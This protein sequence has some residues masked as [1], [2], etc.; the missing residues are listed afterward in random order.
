ETGKIDAG[1]YESMRGELRARAVTLL[2]AE[3]AERE[4]GEQADRSAASGASAAPGLEA[5]E[6]KR[7]SGTGPGSSGQPA[8]GPHRFCPACGSALTEGWRFCAGCGAE[9]PQAA[10]ESP[11]SQPTR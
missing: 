11:A 6:G 1:E 4:A 3:R 10:G 8:A 9:L 2:R 7:P 5:A